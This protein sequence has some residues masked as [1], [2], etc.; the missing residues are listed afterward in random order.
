MSYSRAKKLQ[1]LLRMK[2]ITP[3]MTRGWKAAAIP[4]SQPVTASSLTMTATNTTA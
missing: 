3:P 1:G 4:P 2:A